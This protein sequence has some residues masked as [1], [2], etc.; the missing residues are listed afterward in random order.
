M[1]IKSSYFFAAIALVVGAVHI[2][3]ADQ[4]PSF[5][6]KTG[7]IEIGDNIAVMNLPGDFRYLDPK[8]SKTVIEDLWG[9]PEGSADGVLGMI[10]PSNMNPIADDSWGI[11]ITYEDSGFV[12]DDDADKIDYDELLSTMKEEIKESNPERKK[13]GYSSIELVGWATPPHYDKASHK[14]FWAKELKFEGSNENT[15]NYNFRI[16]GRKGVL[17]LNA[18][19]GMKQLKDIESKS[20]PLLES[21][22]FSDGNRYA[23]YVPGKDRVAEFGIA[24]LI[25]GGAAAAAKTGLLKSLWVGI[26]AAKKFI[27]I[28]LIAAAGFVKK[29]FFSK[30]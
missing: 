7:K 20:A 24:A 23:E 11:V 13:A 27:I 6:W 25:A 19:S 30:K 28:G 2:F 18:V 10:F 12:K 14:L 22:N 17:V 9:N 4:A 16:L 5:K 26:L 21:V 29:F 15:L 1:K 8:Q 3:A